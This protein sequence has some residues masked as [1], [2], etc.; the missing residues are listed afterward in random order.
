MNHLR[1]RTRMGLV[2]AVL[3]LTAAAVAV[4]GYVQLNAVN[5]RLQHMVDHTARANEKAAQIRIDLMH[6]LR[7]ERQASLSTDDEE[8]RRYARE[9]REISQRI[10]REQEELAPMLDGEAD[11]DARRH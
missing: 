7:L 9:S 11:A 4:T 10:V 6:C 3:V 5:A 1:L 2:L 8:S